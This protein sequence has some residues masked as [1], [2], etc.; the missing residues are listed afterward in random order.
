MPIAQVRHQ[1]HGGQI[2]SEAGIA[3]RNLLEVLAW[4]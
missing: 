4:R 3:S 2:E 1:F